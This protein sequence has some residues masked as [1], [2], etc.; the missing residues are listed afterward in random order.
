[1]RTLKTLIVSIYRV[2]RSVPTLKKIKKM[3]RENYSREEYNAIVH[4][5]PK[6][7]GRRIF[8]ST[9]SKIVVNGDE[10]IHDSQVLFVSN[11]Q[12]NFDIFALLGYLKKPFGFISKIEVKKIPIARTWMEKMDCLF[13]DRKDRR[14]SLKT[15]KQGIELLKDGHSLLIFPEGTRARRDELLEFKSGSLS[16]ARKA[17]VPVQPVMING[18]YNIMEANNNRIRKG[19]VYLTVCDPILPEEYEHMSLDELADE[20]KK[21]I[22]EAMD[23]TKK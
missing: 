14:Q 4:E 21:R 20:T 23:Q 16:L 17:N 13:L 18:T 3:D 12:G 15:F 7:I 1:M 22:Q 11:H 2:L 8:K 10:K 6:K 19:K 9:G 5:L